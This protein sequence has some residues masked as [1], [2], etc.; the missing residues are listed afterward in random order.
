M[1]YFNLLARFC[2]LSSRVNNTDLLTQEEICGKELKSRTA[3]RELSELTVLLM[4]LKEVTRL[5]FISLNTQMK[6]AGR[7]FDRMS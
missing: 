6:S 5:G 2:A 7:I 1:K 4:T 3:Q